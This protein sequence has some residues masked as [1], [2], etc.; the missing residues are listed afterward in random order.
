MQQISV[1]KD[2][3]K[4]TISQLSTSYT[5]VNLHVHQCHVFL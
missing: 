3:I 5:T 2:A 1:K 4:L